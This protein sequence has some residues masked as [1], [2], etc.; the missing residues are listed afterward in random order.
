MALKGRNALAGETS[1][2]LLQHADNPVEWY[3]WSEEALE[4]AR[5]EEKPILLSVGYSACHWCHVMAHESFEDDAT[6]Q[7]MNQHFVNIKVDR[8]ERPDLDKIYQTA[9]QLLTQRAGGWPLTMF[10]T[11]DDHA[12]FYGGTYFPKERRFGM[13]AFREILQ[14]VAQAHRE[15]RADIRQQNDSLVQA[16]H[17]TEPV[18]EH[19]QVINPQPLDEAYHAL[20]SSFDERF[21]GFGGAPKFPHP[22]NLERL[23]RHYAATAAAGE[24]DPRALEMAVASL[25]HMG[26]G[27]IYDHLGGGFCRYS[28]DQFWMIP[29]FEKMLY[30]NGPLL[31]LYAE[32]WQLTGDPLFRQIARRTEE[33][34]MREMQAPEGGYYSSLDADSE[35]EEGKFYVW[36]PD[37]AKAHLEEDEYR[38]LAARYGLEGEPNFEGKAWHLHTFKD[39]TEVASDLGANEDR[40]RK[41]VSS[42]QGKLYEVRSGRIW[43]GRDEKVLASWN[44]LMIKGMATAARIF[45]DADCLDSAERALDFVRSR[46][47]RDGRLRVTYKDGQ[48]KYAAYLD[49]HAFILDALLCL[50]QC[51]WRS[52]DLSFA[53]EIADLM[54]ARFQDEANGGFF[55]TADDHESLF[56]RPKP[57]VDDALP[58][59]NGIA[60]YALARLGHLLGETRYLDAVERTL[61]AGWNGL[62]RYPHAHNAL[63]LAVEEYLDPPQIIV[64]RGEGAELERWRTR[65][66]KKYAPRRV[67][68]AIAANETDLPGLLGERAPRG[69]IVA[70]V[71]EGR[72]CSAPVSDYEAL[73]SAL[74]PLEVQTSGAT[75][76]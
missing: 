25:T 6:A 53:V 1:P 62:Q 67:C 52:E 51:R 40:C 73:E 50:L 76:G 24:A 61:R 23:L 17:G 60:A 20:Q 2:Y 10:L 5:A 26:N 57:M 21:G 12:P 37:E 31:T 39:W 28:V 41:L 22:T 30:D 70:Y 74:A 3:P 15:R 32:A 71:C 29:H 64:L 4:K 34:V 69:S 19:E 46:L 9:H 47:W 49:D 59:G 45:G 18:A 58:S 11:A 44:A 54:L 16:M 33:W 48:A 66:L 65:C 13:P 42:A 75:A 7:I 14:W 38:A 43:P 68:F 72:V 36:T 63:L 8:E 27:G 55:F 35:G 56:H